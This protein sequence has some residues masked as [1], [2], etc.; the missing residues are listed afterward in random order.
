MDTYDAI[1]RRA[2]TR[3]FKPDPVPRYVIERLLAAAVR[4]PN[5]KLTEPW[6]FVVVTG[7]AKRRYAELRKAHRAKRFEGRTD[8]QAV[9]AIE[10][11]YREHLDTPAFIFVLCAVSDDP[12]RREEDY[13]ATMM[14]IE[15]L[16]V[17][18]A[19]D[20]LGTYVRTGGIMELPEARALAGAPEG[21]RIVAIVSLGYLAAPPEPT[22]RKKPLGELVTWLE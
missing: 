16:L 13:G 22:P 5:H 2:S 3:S 4:A 20:G 15:N 12:V 9:R 17:A 10:K 1:S 7:E 21:Q 18:A 6:R 11:T 19:A 14:A 8:D